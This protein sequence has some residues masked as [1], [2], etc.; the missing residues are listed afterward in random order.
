M[1]EL[2]SHPRAAEIETIWKLS[3]IDLMHS[4][5]SEATE[6][7]RKNLPDDHLP[8]FS[9]ETTELAD[10]IIRIFDYVGAYDLPV[11]EAIVAKMEYNSTRPYMHGNKKA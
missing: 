9:M 10:V 8:Q 3:R 4:E 1:E 7:I 11:A 6:G 5:A 2:R